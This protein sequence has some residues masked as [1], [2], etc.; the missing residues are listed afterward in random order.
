MQQF[1]SA[2]AANAQ[3]QARIDLESQTIFV[4]SLSS[5]SNPLFFFVLILFLLLSFVAVFLLPF[6]STLALVVLLRNARGD[7]AKARIAEAGADRQHAPA[8]DLRHERRLAQS[9]HHCIIVHDH[10]R[11]V[12]ADRWD[13][14]DDL[15][16]QVEFS[17]LP[18]AAGEV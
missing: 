14:L 3:R 18:I 9:L 1:A 12:I 6:I 7:I 5:R 13:R 17:A 4:R 15:A 8:L 2:V 11:I 10:M 16:R